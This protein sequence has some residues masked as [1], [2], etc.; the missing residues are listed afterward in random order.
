MAKKTQVLLLDDID[1]SPADGT[2]EFGIDGQLY[3]IDLSVKHSSELYAN[4]E[5]FREAGTR[6]G[7]IHLGKTRGP[8]AAPVRKT[9]G[10]NRDR[11][12]AIRAWAAQQKIDVS[13]RGRI[14]EAVVAKFDAAHAA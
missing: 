14:A 13:P 5:K 4:L 12:A 1:G 3:S 9:P 8:A 7:K 2:I 10:T 11:N 6:L